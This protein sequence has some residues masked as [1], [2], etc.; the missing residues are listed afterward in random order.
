MMFAG[1]GVRDS[2]KKVNGTQ[3]YRIAAIGRG[4]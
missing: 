4:P 2:L 1:S 3:M